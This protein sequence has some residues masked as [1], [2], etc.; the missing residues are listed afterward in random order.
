MSKSKATLFI[1]IDPKN[2]VLYNA[3]EKHIA[4]H[5]HKIDTDPF[6][7]SGFDII[8]PKTHFLQPNIFF[9]SQMVDFEIKTEMEY[10]GNPAAFYIHPR[11]SI[12]KT[13]LMLANHTGIIDAGY[14]G[15][16]KGAFRNL[17]PNS[18]YVMEVNTRVLQICHPS[19]CP[20]RVILQN[21]LT[22]TSRGEGGFGST[23]R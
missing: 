16:I 11:S 13:P 18:E 4:A 1:Y 9:A 23:G 3:Y 19:L 22:E 2:I 10:E 5:N 8:T 21:S 15:N 6:P 7:D 17:D 20:I 12:S 14:R